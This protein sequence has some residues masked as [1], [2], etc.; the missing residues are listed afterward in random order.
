[1]VNL[2]DIKELINIQ[3]EVEEKAKKIF[4]DFFKQQLSNGNLLEKDIKIK[5]KIVKCINDLDVPNN[6]GLYVILSDYK[7]KINFNKFE[8]RESIDEKEITLKAVYRGEASHRKNRIIG[9]LFKDQYKGTDINFMNVDGH[10]GIDIFSNK[11]YCKYN[12]MVITYSLDKCKQFLR[13]KM[14]QAFDEV[15]GDGKKPIFSDK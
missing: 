3:N 4:V 12:W 5:K 11:K 10:N 1:M 7:V 13:L 15:F 6:S 2:Y 8:V 14:E 9:H